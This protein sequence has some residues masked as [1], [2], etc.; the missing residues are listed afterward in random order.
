MTDISVNWR[1]LNFTSQLQRWIYAL[2]ASDQLHFR[3]GKPK[4]EFFTNVIQPTYLTKI[5]WFE[6]GLLHVPLP[7]LECTRY[8]V[9]QPDQPTNTIFCVCGIV[10]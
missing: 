7:Q 8:L 4:I 1:E 6:V 5:L 10:N 9:H 3:T 2:H